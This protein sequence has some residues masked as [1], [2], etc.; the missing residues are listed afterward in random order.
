MSIFKDF[1]KDF[2][3]AYV[4]RKKYKLI[5]AAGY[6]QIQALRNIRTTKGTSLIKRGTKGG[7]VKEKSCLSH[8]GNCWIDKYSYI[9][10]GV[11]IE[12]DAYVCGN[13][14]EGDGRRINNSNISKSLV[15]KDNVF[16]A[17]NIIIYTGNKSDPYDCAIIRDNVHT[18]SN[19]TIRYPNCTIGGNIILDEALDI[20]NSHIILSSNTDIEIYRRNRYTYNNGATSTSSSDSSD[21]SLTYDYIMGRVNGNMGIPEQQSISRSRRQ[22]GTQGAQGTPNYRYY[23]DTENRYYEDMNRYYEYEYYGYEYKKII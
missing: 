21:S 1:L 7:Y 14:M 23:I 18:L 8:K 9:T 20:T 12:G 3:D 22:Q 17:S 15:I 5:P 13:I 11:F 2:F 4:L 10:S 19:L 6:Y 16:I